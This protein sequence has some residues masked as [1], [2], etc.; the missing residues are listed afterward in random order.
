VLILAFIIKLLITK[1]SIK[2]YLKTLIIKSIYPD[3]KLSFNSLLKTEK[4]FTI[5]ISIFSLGF[6]VT[7]FIPTTHFPTYADDSF[8]NRNRPTYHIYQ[9]GGVKIF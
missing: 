8:G 2:D 9:D 4:I 5:I 1:T 6:I 7:T 3:I